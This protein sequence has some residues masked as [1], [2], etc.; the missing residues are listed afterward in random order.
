M[1]VIKVSCYVNEV[2]FGKLLGNLRI[3]GLEFSVPPLGPS[4]RGKRLKI[5]FNHQ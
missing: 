1:M 3:G 2:T 4:G 5:E